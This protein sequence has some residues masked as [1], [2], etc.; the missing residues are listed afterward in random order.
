MGKNGAIQIAYYTIQQGKSAGV[1]KFY[2]KQKQ[3]TLKLFYSV[4]IKKSILK[5]DP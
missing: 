5:Y 3:V 1:K 2:V 4:R